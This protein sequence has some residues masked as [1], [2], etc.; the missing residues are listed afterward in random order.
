MTCDHKGCRCTETTVVQGDQR[1]CSDRCANA[2]VLEQG[3]AGCHC[4][5]ADCSVVS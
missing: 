2:E 3:E 4:G 5:H 1:F